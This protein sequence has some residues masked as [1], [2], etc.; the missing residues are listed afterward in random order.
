MNGE[1]KMDELYHHGVK[2]M[3]WGVIRWR[4]K[5]GSSGNGSRRVS[6]KVRKQRAANLEKARQ[7]RAKKQQILRS[8]K[9]KDILKNKQMF[10]N[11]EIQQA[12]NRFNLEKQLK[13]IDNRQT[14][15]GKKMAMDILENSAKNI[16][17]QTVTYLMGKGTN[18]VLSY[19]FRNDPMPINPKKG[20]KDK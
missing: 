8:G 11:D 1:F 9:A 19:Y 2:G 4:N 20:Q 6:R 18:K 14:S 15:R 7:T 13:D 5:S 10:T 3:K 17:T 12:L 16:G